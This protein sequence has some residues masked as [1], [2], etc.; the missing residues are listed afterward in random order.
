MNKKVSGSFLR[1]TIK[2][3]CMHAYVCIHTHTHTH[4]DIFINHI[5]NMLLSTDGLPPS[6]PFLFSMML[7]RRHQTFS[8]MCVR[9][10]HILL[11]LSKYFSAVVS[12]PTLLFPASLS[13]CTIGRYA[14]CVFSVFCL[15][16]IFS[17]FLRS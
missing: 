15:V 3:T 9:L 7:V 17:A 2:G 13:W 5:A 8:V 12:T 6:F 10:L 11:C 4:T 14:V 1:N 16:W